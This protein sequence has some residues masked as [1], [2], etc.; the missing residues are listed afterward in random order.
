MTSPLEKY[1]STKLDRQSPAPGRP[2]IDP[3]WSSGAKTAVGTALAIQSRVWFTIAEGVLTEVYFPDID[4]AN[5]RGL[6][7]LVTDDRFFS[8]E[9]HDATHMVS[10]LSPG[11]PAFRIST[12]C[13]KGRYR[14]QKEVIADPARDCLLINVAFEPA[15]DRKNVRL[16]LIANPHVGDRGNPNNAWVGQYKSIPMLFSQAEGLALAIASS[17]KFAGLSC[18]FIGK[19]DGL[20]D[21]R[22]HKRMTHFY[23]EASKGN[24]S[25]ASEID[26]RACQ[27]KFQVALA[28]G[29]HPAEAGQQARAGLL[30]DF[31]SVRDK[32]IHGWEAEQEKFIDLSTGPIAGVDHFRASVAV[33]RTHESKRFPG[34]FIASLS[35]PWGFDRGDQATGGYHVLWPRDMGETVLGLL[36]CGDAESARRALFYLRCTQENDG[37]WTQNMWL[38]GTPHWTSTQMDGTSFGILI[39]DALRR[40]GQLTSTEAWPM[41]QAAA[42]FLVRNGPVT[43]EDRWEANPG[44]SPYTM[45]VEV[46]ALLA[47]ADFADANSCGDLANFFRSTADAWNDQIDELT[48]ASGTKLARKHRVDGYYFRIM[49]PQGLQA[50]SLDRV[51][52]KLKNHVKGK[53][54]HHAIDIISPDALALVRFGL[55][56]ADDPKILNTVKLIDAT[57]KTITTTGPVWHR[58]THDGYGEHKDGSPYHKTGEGR[59]WP[60]LAGERAHYEIAAGNFEQAEL[61]RTTIEAQTSEC[62]MIPEQVWDAADIPKRLLFNGHPTGSGMPLVWAHA[63]YVKLLR[64]LKERKVWDTPP[65][66][67]QRYLV[68]K[69][70][71]PYQIWTEK[72]QRPRLSAGKDLRVDSADAIAVRWSTDGG[73]ITNHLETVDS[74]LGVRWAVLPLSQISAGT[75][76]QFSFHRSPEERSKAQKFEIKIGAAS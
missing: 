33:M 27:G 28:F 10:Y 54:D 20:T 30:Q 8:D 26:W 63:E 75:R 40:A 12:A 68:E 23:T 31:S 11:A 50:A 13:K 55:R 17:A 2:G 25:L 15:P 29:G 70:T 37:N 32:Y 49:P 18:G 7:F 69:K 61:L 74:S 48:Y 36:A 59:G 53:Q 5:L 47:A 22:A 58:Y 45:A 9:Q 3:T 38:D 44:Y 42:G 60:L 71:S 43:E 16:Y 21:I 39:A 73:R 41:I 62:G 46:A 65:Q 1:A 57:L 24:V 34:G 66:T 19:N 64:S 35:I 72:Q 56:A 4:R 6:R 51:I 76:V 52:T 67:V 14:L